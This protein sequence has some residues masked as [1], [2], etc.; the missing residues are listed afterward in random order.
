[1]AW[2][3]LLGRRNPGALVVLV[4][5]GADG[6]V[7]LRTGEAVIRVHV[8]SVAAAGPARAVRPLWGSVLHAWLTAGVPLPDLLPATVQLSELATPPLGA[9]GVVAWRQTLRLVRH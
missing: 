1:M 2:A 5:G 8:A 7:L 6:R 3:E 4:H 9:A